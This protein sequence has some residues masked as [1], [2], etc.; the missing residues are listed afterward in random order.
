MNKVLEKDETVAELA[1]RLISELKANHRAQSLR[2]LRQGSEEQG[3]R[4]ESSK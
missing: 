3:Q 4:R 1:E 2:L